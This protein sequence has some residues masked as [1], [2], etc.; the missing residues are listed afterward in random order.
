[1]LLVVELPPLRCNHS[2]FE[3]PAQIA[4]RASRS[5]FLN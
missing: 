3:R 1:V 2:R 4:H 5:A